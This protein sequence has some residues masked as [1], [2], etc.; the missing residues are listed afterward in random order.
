MAHRSVDIGIIKC[1]KSIS[2]ITGE[3]TLRILSFLL[4]TIIF[5]IIPH[6]YADEVDDFR[7][8]QTQLIKIGNKFDAVD[9]NIH[10]YLTDLQSKEGIDSLLL[11]YRFDQDVATF[12]ADVAALADEHY[13]NFSLHAGAMEKYA[14]LNG[15][16]P[17]D[18]NNLEAQ[19]RTSLS[20][21]E[22]H[23]AWFTSPEVVTNMSKRQD[24]ARHILG[25]PDKDN[26]AD[27]HNSAENVF[28]SFAANSKAAGPY[29]MWAVAQAIGVKRFSTET[30]LDISKNSPE[31]QKQRYKKRYEQLGETFDPIIFSSLPEG[32]EYPH[33]YNHFKSEIT[34]QNSGD[35]LAAIQSSQKIVNRN[36]FALHGLVSESLQSEMKQ[37]IS[38][39][40]VIMDKFKTLAEARFGIENWQDLP[41]PTDN[42][43][44]LAKIWS[45][46][47]YQLM[48]RRFEAIEKMA[49]PKADKDWLEMNKKLGFE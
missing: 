47:E 15:L 38:D 26:L 33:D 11:I 1:I 14:Q 10:Q 12:S 40:Q 13:K 29:Q 16:D 48:Q 2:N 4:S 37:A 3:K 24:M 25:T 34:Y 46:E 6:A 49:D 36:L 31:R 7:E 21:L 8:H 44:P 9:H 39:Y 27:L 22:E 41:M 32:A 30:G 20:H 5:F 43:L 42:W 28:F 23:I 19:Y 18:R 45:I 17:F 35:D